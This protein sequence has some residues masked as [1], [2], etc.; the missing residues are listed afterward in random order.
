MK[1]WRVRGQTFPVASIGDVL[2]SW[3]AGTGLSRWRVVDLHRGGIVHVEAIEDGKRYAEQPLPW[4]TLHTT[5]TE[6]VAVNAERE[7]RQATELYRQLSQV[8]RAHRR[9]EDLSRWY[10]GAWPHSEEVICE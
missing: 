2:Y 1:G 10:D 8:L 9:G 7:R 4:E 3:M 6:A 5:A